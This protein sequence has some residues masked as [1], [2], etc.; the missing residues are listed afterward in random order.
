[1][2]PPC[3]QIIWKACQKKKAFLSFHHKR[4]CLECLKRYLKFNW[5]H[6]LLSDETNIET[7]NTQGGFGIKRMPITK[8]YR[9]SVC[10]YGGGGGSVVLW[11]CFCSKGHGNHVKVHGII[12]SIQY[13]EFFNVNLACQETKTG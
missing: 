2:S 6:G 5:K 11:G 10:K 12:N 9:H 8:M 4:K 7:T 3:L 1:M 13:Q